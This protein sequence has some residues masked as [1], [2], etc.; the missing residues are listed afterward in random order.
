MLVGIESGHLLSSTEEE[1]ILLVAIASSNSAEEHANNMC[2][3]SERMRIF[4]RRKGVEASFSSTP[5]R[6]N[7]PSWEL[8]SNGRLQDSGPLRVYVYVIW[9]VFFFLWRFEF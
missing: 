4:L 7:R 6:L 2:L 5:I 3:H 8:H 9:F 1:K